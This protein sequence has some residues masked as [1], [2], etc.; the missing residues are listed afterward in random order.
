MTESLVILNSVA[1]YRQENL[2]SSGPKW[3]KS[4]I[5]QGNKN[6]ISTYIKYST[7]SKCFLLIRMQLQMYNMTDF[8]QIC[9]S[10][11]FCWGFGLHN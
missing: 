9:K 7:K 10:L 3:A 1:S 6:T 5:S 8:S 11:H 4:I 2:F